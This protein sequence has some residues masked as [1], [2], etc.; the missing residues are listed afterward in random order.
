LGSDR[1]LAQEFVDS[2]RTLRL[3][4]IVEAHIEENRAGGKILVLN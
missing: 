1:G 4:E 3:E 2:R